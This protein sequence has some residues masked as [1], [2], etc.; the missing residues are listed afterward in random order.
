MAAITWSEA[1]ALQ[2]PRMD[3]THREFVDLVCQLEAALDRTPAELDAVMD[4]LVRHTE[5]HFAQE[6]SWMAQ[7]GFAPQNCHTFQH[8]SVLELLREVRRR[9]QE[10]GD[11]AT[12]RA[13]V[14]GLVEWFP[15]HAQSMDAALAMTMQERGF[16]PDTGALAHPIPADAE[17]ITGC[18]GAS[19][20]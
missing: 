15:V 3:T 8:A 18:G 19:C 9:L 20:G 5:A 11:V 2:Q 12:V 1:L 16:D 14:P 6:E 10:E 7:I 4:N 17:V 13:L